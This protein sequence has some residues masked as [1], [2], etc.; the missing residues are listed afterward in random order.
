MMINN[1][2]YNN[3]EYLRD[4]W[5]KDKKFR[6]RYT[7]ETTK[8]ILLRAKKYEEYTKKYGNDYPDMVEK[9]KYYIFFNQN[10]NNFLRSQDCDIG[11][12]PWDDKEVCDLVSYEITLIHPHLGN[13]NDM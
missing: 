5:S 4:P 1:G 3:I 7:F 8:I 6:K 10:I 12:R 13:N 11:K 2:N 9:D